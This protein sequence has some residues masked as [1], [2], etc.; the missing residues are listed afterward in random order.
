MI[1]F[2][3]QKRKKF[4]TVR[5]EDYKHPDYDFRLILLNFDPETGEEVDETVVLIN[6]KALAEEIKSLLNQAE[7]LNQILTDI[8][9]F[10]GQF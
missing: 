1:T 10:E 6:Q 2:D 8:T 4:E 7:I 9:N 5:L 3:Y